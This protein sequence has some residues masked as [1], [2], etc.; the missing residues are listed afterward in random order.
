[1]IDLKPYFH[2]ASRIT[3]K[4]IFGIFLFGSQNYN[5]ADE[6][7]DIDVY[8]LVFPDHDNSSLMAPEEYKMPNDERI[9]FIDIRT[10]LMNLIGGNLTY[11]ELLTTSNYI[12]K[13]KYAF[14]WSQL[15]AHA[16]DIAYADPENTFLEIKHFI[17]DNYIRFMTKAASPD[18][19]KKYG[20]APK[21]AA[22]VLRGYEILQRYNSREDVYK[23]FITERQPF[24]YSVKRAAFSEPMVNSIVADIVKKIDA[25]KL[26]L[27]KDKNE[28]T[29]SFVKKIALAIE[30]ARREE[31]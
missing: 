31:V 9:E 10:F 27:P 25:T 17:V 5:L 12:V 15:R 19:L 6:E 11:L 16:N 2:E 26:M 22:H 13:S 30:K 24:I 29:I 23:I 18:N 4:E 7:S 3:N 14:Y 21:Q 20:F 28:D 8:C 1:M